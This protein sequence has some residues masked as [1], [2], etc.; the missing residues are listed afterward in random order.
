MAAEPIWLVE[1]TIRSWEC[2]SRAEASAIWVPFLTL[3]IHN[4]IV[5]RMKNE[6]TRPY[7]IIVIATSSKTPR[8]PKNNKENGKNSFRILLKHTTNCR[9]ATEAR[10]AC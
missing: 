4:I 7:S 2:I 9:T 3:S 5:A 6:F 10:Y 1:T 8:Q